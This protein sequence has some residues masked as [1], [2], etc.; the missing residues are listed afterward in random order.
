MSEY[1]QT[2]RTVLTRSKLS[3]CELLKTSTS[4]THESLDQR[5]MRADPFS[6]VSRYKQFLRMQYRFHWLV[7]PLFADSELNQTLDRVFAGCRLQQVI[8][9]CLDLDMS[10]EYLAAEVEGLDT[11]TLS[12]YEALGWLYTIEGS[13]I[14]GAFL[15]KFVQKL[16]FDEN[17]AAAHLAGHPEGRGKH[18]RNFK[19]QLD[20]LELN[21]SERALACEGAKNAF[22][23]VR[24]QVEEL[25]PDRS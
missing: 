4:S 2:H 5:I 10:P 22:Q 17:Q 15:Y 13:N 19:A 20:A 18:W 7:S 14:G 16:G 25:L 6:D 1:T 3:L 23:F 24:S 9:D 8:S 11:L 21:H 12:P